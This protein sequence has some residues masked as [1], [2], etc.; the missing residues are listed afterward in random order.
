MHSFESSE[1]LREAMM[2][3]TVNS[4]QLWALDDVDVRGGLWLATKRGGIKK[5]C[6]HA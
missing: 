4:R 3:L 2:R 5:G 1:S 6:K